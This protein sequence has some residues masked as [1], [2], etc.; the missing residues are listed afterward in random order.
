MMMQNV[1]KYFF[2][3]LISISIFS[4]AGET[5]YLVNLKLAKNAVISY[6]ENGGFHKDAMDAVDKAK[7]EFDKISPSK[8][9]V[10]IFDIDET[11]LSNYSVTKS[12]DFAYI[13]KEWDKW[14]DSAKAPAIPEVKNLYAY[15]IARGFKIIFISGRKNFQRE[16]TRKNMIEVGYTDFDTLIFKTPD[17]FGKTALKYKSDKRTEI[18]KAGYKIVGTVGDQWSDLEGPYHG[19]QVKIPNYQYYIE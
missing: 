2:V 13:E 15:L 10:V 11:A 9:S 3:L 6:R 19:I 12:L 16:A 17:Y 5:N 4:C 14:I 8:N 18:E 7:I 1:S